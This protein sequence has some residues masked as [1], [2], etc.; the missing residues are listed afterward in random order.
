M[1]YETFNRYT[2]IER[3]ILKLA[4]LLVLHNQHTVMCNN[5]AVVLFTKL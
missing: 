1:M 2:F 4:L 3:V 5:K